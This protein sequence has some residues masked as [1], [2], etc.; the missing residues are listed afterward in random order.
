MK[1]YY[2]NVPQVQ[3]ILWLNELFQIQS[4]NIIAC[5]RSVTFL[6][7]HDSSHNAF[8]EFA[9]DVAVKLADVAIDLAALVDGW[10]DLMFGVV[11]FW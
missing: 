8:R 2:W 3:N 7:I 1:C 4:P 10:H 11:K 9:P 6:Y 5:D